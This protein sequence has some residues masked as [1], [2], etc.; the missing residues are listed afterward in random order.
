MRRL[1]TNEFV[2]KAIKV[3]SNKYDYS[4]TEYCG[5]HKKVKIVCPKHGLF[6]QRASTHLE[7]RGCP[8]CATE[9]HANNLREHRRNSHIKDIFIKR[10]IDVHGLKYDYSQVEYKNVHT[11]VKIICPVHGEF[12]QTPS[13]H[14]YSKCGCP[15]CATHIV[16]IEKQKLFAE[17]FKEKAIAIHGQKYDYDDVN[18]VHARSKVTIHCPKHGLFKQTPNSHLNGHGCPRCSQI[19]FINKQWFNNH[20]EFRDVDSLLYCI[21]CSTKN[22]TFIKIGITTRSLSER[23]DDEI[24]HLYNTEII[25]VLRMSLLQSFCIEQLIVNALQDLAFNPSQNFSGKTECFK[26][27]FHVVLYIKT[28]FN[29]IKEITQE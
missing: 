4:I 2:V 26:D 14:I 9:K 25:D 19:G 17:K 1:S 11:K 18:Y 6:S 5:S 20:P 27:D 29:I 22:E 16:K 24:N 10:A 12:K 13:K 23:L 28:M 8:S 21:K 3:H 7:G 15:N